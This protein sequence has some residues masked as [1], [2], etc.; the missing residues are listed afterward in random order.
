MERALQWKTSVTPFLI[1][2]GASQVALVIKT[3]PA[4]AG[5]IRDVDSIPRWG[6]SPGERN[7]NPLQYSCL[8]CPMDRGAWRATVHGVS[9]SWTW[10]KRLSSHV[11]LSRE[12]RSRFQSKFSCVSILFSDTFESFVLINVSHGW[13]I[14][15]GQIEKE[16]SIWLL[17]DRGQSECRELNGGSV[18]PK[19]GSLRTKA[20][21]FLGN[22]GIGHIEEVQSG[23]WGHRS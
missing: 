2:F 5:D 6:R 15:E 17:M 20:W 19:A 18:A 23:E 11:I 4:N 1:L 21:C 22:S 8:E 16:S 3:F 7:G 9:K 14:T 12:K 13:Q 10:L